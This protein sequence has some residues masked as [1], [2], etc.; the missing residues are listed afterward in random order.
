MDIT[1]DFDIYRWKLAER[2]AFEKVA[3]M[4]CER[5]L[6]L[7]AAVA[8]GD[9]VDEEK[10]LDVPAAVHA[11]FVWIAARRIEPG[12]TF[13]QATER[14]DGMAFIDAIPEEEPAPLVTPNRA[15]RRSTKKSAAPSATTSTTPP[16]KSSN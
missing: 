15:A 1:L 6:S 11:A 13:E 3:G 2:I 4:T 9:G 7:F 10:A 16:P 14:F 5:A 12:L 8:E